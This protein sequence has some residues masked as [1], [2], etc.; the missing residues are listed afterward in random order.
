MA[1]S[2]R[3]VRACGVGGLAVVGDARTRC[4]RSR[5]LVAV[6]VLEGVQAEPGAVQDLAAVADGAGGHDHPHPRVAGGERGDP[7]GGLRRV[8]A[9]SNSSSRPSNITTARPSARR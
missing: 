3:V 1:A 7:P 4:G 5:D 6:E 8:G 2:S 9:G